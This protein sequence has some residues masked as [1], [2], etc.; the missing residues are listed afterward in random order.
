MNPGDTIA[1][2]HPAREAWTMEIAL[3][4][5]KYADYPVNIETVKTMATFL[6][7]Y[8]DELEF[9]GRV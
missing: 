2:D 9:P 3:A 7:T 5:E 1:D 4:S 6:T 8:M